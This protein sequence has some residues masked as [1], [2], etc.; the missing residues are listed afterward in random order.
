MLIMDGFSENAH[1]WLAGHLSAIVRGLRSPRSYF[2]KDYQ[3]SDP[4]QKILTVEQ[5]PMRSTQCGSV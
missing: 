5:P 4:I 1:P 2:G 3:N